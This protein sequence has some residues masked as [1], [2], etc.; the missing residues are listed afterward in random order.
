MTRNQNQ[1]LIRKQQETN[2]FDNLDIDLNIVI[3]TLRN[4]SLNLKVIVNQDPFCRIASL[5]FTCLEF[6]IF[7]ADNKAVKSLITKIRPEGIE[8]GHVEE[9]EALKKLTSILAEDHIDQLVDIKTQ[10]HYNHK[11]FEYYRNQKN[12]IQLPQDYDHNLSELANEIYKNELQYKTHQKLDQ[13]PDQNRTIYLNSC[14]TVIA[15]KIKSDLTIIN[16]L[17]KECLTTISIA[18][19]PKIDHSSFTVKP[20]EEDNRPPISKVI[21]FFENLIAGS[22][23]K[24]TKGSQNLPPQKE[25]SSS[26]KAPDVDISRIVDKFEKRQDI[27]RQQKEGSKDEISKE[28]KIRRVIWADKFGTATIPGICGEQHADWATLIALEVRNE[29]NYPS[30]S[31]TA[32]L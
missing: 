9:L 32:S 11:L 18:K 3:E 2:R 14:K 7:L 1:S 4:P 27:L 23:K 13:L 8:D 28:Q 25:Y 29:R 30:R 12:P 22:D 5:R 17:I 16:Q 6:V 21:N 15:D 24:L 26:K 19:K 31:H 20:V 10:L